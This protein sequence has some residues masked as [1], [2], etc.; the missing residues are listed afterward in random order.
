MSLSRRAFLVALVVG[1]ALSPAFIRYFSLNPTQTDSGLL[2]RNTVALGEQNI[3]RLG[4]PIRLKIP[5][6]DVD[7]PIDYVGLTP[8]GDLDIPKGPTNAG[9]YKSGPRPGEKGSSVVDGHF[10]WVNGKAAVFDNLHKLRKGDV[11]TVEDEKGST[12][13]FVVSKSQTY[14][15]NDIATAVFRSSD[16]KAHLNLITCQG[17]WNTNQDSYSARLVVFAEKAIKVNQ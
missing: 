14:A 13:M 10:G 4:L 8:Q 15:P 12:T 17:D 6:I 3:A 2:N 11:I 16:G 9:W 7:A 1:V 5:K